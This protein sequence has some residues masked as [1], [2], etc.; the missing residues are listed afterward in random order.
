MNSPPFSPLSSAALKAQFLDSFETSEEDDRI[1]RYFADS[2]PGA[3]STFGKLLLD[4]KKT[5]ITHCK[6]LNV[7]LHLVSNL[8]HS[9]AFTLQCFF[10]SIVGESVNFAVLSTAI[11][12]AVT[13]PI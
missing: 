5:S 6:F 3:K 4:R 1:S 9:I 8:L 12:S 13:G 11:F 2:P 10:L 7:S